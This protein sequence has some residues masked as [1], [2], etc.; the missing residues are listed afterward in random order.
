MLQFLFTIMEHLQTYHKRNLPHYYPHGEKIF[1]TFR[2]ANTIPQ[3]LL[4]EWIEQYQNEL[5]NIKAPTN[6]AEHLQLRDDIGK[7]HFGRYDKYLDQESD[8]LYLQQPEIAEIVKEALLYYENNLYKTLAYC[9]MPNHVH[10]VFDTSIQLNKPVDE[11]K[12]LSIFMKSI[13]G[14]T[15]KK[16]NEVLGKTGG[17]WQTESYD[18]VIRSDKELENIINYVLNNPVKAKLVENSRDWVYNFSIL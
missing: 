4:V 11:Y 18:R 3:N 16:C 1:V 6:S 10:W 8:I 12:N 14:Y 9:I 13:K 15:G 2:L 17:F 5:N 7:R